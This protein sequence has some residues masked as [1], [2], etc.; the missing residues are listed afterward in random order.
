MSQK[1]KSNFL[2][3]LSHSLVRTFGSAWAKPFGSV[4][5]SD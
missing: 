5:N 1:V 3:G 2:F 4:Q